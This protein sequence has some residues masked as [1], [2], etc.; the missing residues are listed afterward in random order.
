M[1]PVSHESGMMPDLQKSFPQSSLLMPI[2][3]ANLDEA[4]FGESLLRWLKV[5]RSQ[6]F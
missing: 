6:L 1:N 5:G 4:E 3:E 2:Q